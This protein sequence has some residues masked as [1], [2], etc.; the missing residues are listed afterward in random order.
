MPAR[1]THPACLGE[2]LQTRKNLSADLPP[3]LRV[4]CPVSLGACRAP[5]PW[6]REPLNV[7][8]LS[9]QYDSN[10]SKQILS[11]T[12]REITGKLH[13]EGGSLRSMHGMTI[14]LEGNAHLDLVAMD[15]RGG[16]FRACISLDVSRAFVCPVFSGPATNPE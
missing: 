12:S 6:Q 16:S 5:L 11:G 1:G 3:H 14:A 9:P 8:S 4:L 15:F 2:A 10:R 13:N 7:N